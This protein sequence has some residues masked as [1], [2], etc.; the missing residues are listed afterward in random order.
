MPFSTTSFTSSANGAPDPRRGRSASR[1]CSSSSP[2]ARVI[3]EALRVISPAP[4]LPLTCS[5]DCARLRTS[6]YNTGPAV[7]IHGRAS[8]VSKLKGCAL[9]G[10]GFGDGSSVE[11]P[12]SFTTTS[13]Q[14]NRIDCLPSS[15]TTSTTT[16]TSTTSS[17]DLPHKA[18]GL[19]P[20]KVT[21]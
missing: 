16:R 17:A 2:A 6:G 14:R 11:S 1:S 12:Q 8:S 7:K 15:A 18:P 10:E 4:P 21:S 5:S 3:P 20:V 19:P 9:R 13:A